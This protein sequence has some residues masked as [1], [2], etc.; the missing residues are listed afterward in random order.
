MPISIING[1]LHSP[2]PP[3]LANKSFRYG[4][5]FFETMKWRGG[6]PLLADDHFERFFSTARALG[7]QVPAL[8]KK[9]R[10]LDEMAQLIK[11]NAAEKLARIRL[12]AWRGEGGLLEGDDTL[13]YAIE[14]WPLDEAMDQF[15]ENGLVIGIYPEARKAADAFSRYK[16]NNFLAYSLAARH[17][18]AMRWNDALLLNTGGRLVD[19]CIANL[20]I[21]KNEKIITPA[22]S[23]GPVDGILRR[24][25]LRHFPIAEASLQ[26]EDLETADE[27]FLS[28]AIRGIRWVRQCG[29]RLYTQS[30]S[31]RLYQQLR[32]TI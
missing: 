15:N 20:F 6:K 24:Q 9:E 32:Q 28:N 10:L 25:L 29:D 4:D 22:L 31:A 16:T 26:P 19:S 5:G 13:H 14:C 23:E 17:A 18:K 21:I 1:S 12:T 30:I 11:K 27:I 7:Y 2:S 3:W 8:L